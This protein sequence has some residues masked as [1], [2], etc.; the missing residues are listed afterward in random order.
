MLMDIWNALR[1]GRP[2]KGRK[3]E[4]WIEIGFQV[5]DPATDFRGAG[6]LGLA[7]LHG[8]VAK[9]EGKRAFKIADTKETEYF[10]ASASLF[11]T[12]LSVELLKGG[13]I[14]SYYWVPREGEEVETMFQSMFEAVWSEFAAHWLVAPDKSMMQFNSTLLDFSRKLKEERLG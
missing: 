10:F 6:Y 5:E 3:S 2:I 12:M 14:L 4:E 8:W 13:Q 11:L 7:N 1:P 9:E